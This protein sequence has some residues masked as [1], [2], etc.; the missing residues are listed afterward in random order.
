MTSNAGTAPQTLSSPPTEVRGLALFL[1]MD[2][3]LARLAPTPDQVMPDPR[4]TAVLRRLEPLLGGRLAIISGRTLSEIDRIT[5]AASPRRRASTGWRSA[6]RGLSRTRAAAP[7]VR[8]AVA[9]FHA[10]AEAHPG[11]IVEDK[12]VAPGCTIAG[13]PTPPRPPNGWP[14]TW[15]AKPA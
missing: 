9:A 5:E 12:S 2:G 13:A 1:D 15:P 10:F 4:R 3:V 6:P 8:T 7:A 14:G 11:V